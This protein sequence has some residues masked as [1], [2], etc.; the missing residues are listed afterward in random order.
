M[1]IDPQNVASAS[2]SSSAPVQSAFGQRSSTAQNS[3]GDH[4][5]LSG[6][7]KVIQ[8]Y[9]TNRSSRVE[10]LTALVRSGQYEVNPARVSSSIV[11]ESIGASSQSSAAVAR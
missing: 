1:K 3:S 10:Q 11:G 2:V 4:A 9:Q 6:T 5:E 7:S 8:S